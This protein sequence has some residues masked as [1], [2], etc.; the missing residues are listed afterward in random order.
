MAKTLSKHGIWGQS[1]AIQELERKVELAAKGWETVLITGERGTGKELLARALHKMGPTRGDKMVTVD[2]AALPPAT[3]ESALFG[4]ERGSFTGAVNRHIG[5][6][7]EAHEGT[8]FLDEISRLPLEAQGRFLR[9]LEERTVQR[10]GATKPVTVKTRII[11]ATNQ[12][13]ADMARHRL[14]LPDLY[15]RLGVLNILCPPLREREGDILPLLER[16]LGKADFARLDEDARESINRHPFPGNIRE[17]RNLCIRLKTF[18]P[19][20]KIGEE[21]IKR[22][23]QVSG[24]CV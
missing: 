2:C 1:P 20:G 18:E 23:L 13:L 11:A 14:F 21:T 19:S 12:D 22:Y 4:H 17:L 10:I 15:D 8:L 5:L 24:A 6:L 7:E 9:F 3:V 16:F